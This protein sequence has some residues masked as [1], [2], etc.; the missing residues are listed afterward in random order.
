MAVVAEDVWAFALEGSLFGQQIVNTFALRIVSAPA[1]TTET[2]FMDQQFATA[3]L[4][5]NDANDIVND[6]RQ[7]QTGQ[8]QL[9][10]WHVKR[11][12][13]ELSNTFVIPVPG[14]PAGL[15]AGDCETGNLALSVERKGLAAGRRSRGRIAVAGLPTTAMAEGR[16]GAA[17]ITSGQALLGD[18]IGVK[19][20]SQG[21]IFEMGFFSPAHEV[22]RKDGTLVLYPRQFTACHAGSVK[23]T[24]RV[25]RSRT[26]GV[27]T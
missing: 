6:I 9:R 12:E 1:G 11:V 3:D 13:G 2:A 21:V 17:T 24:V 27:G 26:V 23:G 18:M 25:Q 10:N 15:G 20:N 14:Q 16:W 5:F 22:R 7:L 8:V 19:Q 4:N